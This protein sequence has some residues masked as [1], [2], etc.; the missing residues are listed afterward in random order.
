MKRTALN[1]LGVVLIGMSLVWLVVTAPFTPP[2]APHI[3]SWLTPA[4][5]AH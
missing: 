3:G 5:Q 4:A 1:A 2:A